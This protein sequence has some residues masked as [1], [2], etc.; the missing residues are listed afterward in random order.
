MHIYIYIYIYIYIN[1]TSP[2]GSHSSVTFPD[3]YITSPVPVLFSASHIRGIGELRVAANRKCVLLV[4]VPSFN[5]I[6]SKLKYFD[7]GRKPRHSKRPK[8]AVRINAAS[9]AA[10]R[11]D[12]SWE[13]V[14]R[15][16]VVVLV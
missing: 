3:E 10:T 4:L 6:A 15:K 2:V 7:L 12:F 5:I 13:P 1:M 9:I 8:R 11:V 16:N 14:V